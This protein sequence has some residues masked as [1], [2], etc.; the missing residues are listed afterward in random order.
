VAFT[1][2]ALGTFVRDVRDIVQLSAIVLI[3]LMPIVYLP[4]QIP[5]AFNPILWLN[6]FTYMV[7]VYQDVLYFGRVQHPLSWVAFGAGSLIA[8]TLGYRL[9]RR[10][11]PHFANVL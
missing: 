2:A 7:Y 8:F 3:F 4:S 9:F 5:A 11:K 10:V 1:L 6:P